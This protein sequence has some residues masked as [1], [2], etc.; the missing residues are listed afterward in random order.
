MYL[1]H[2]LRIGLDLQ[3]VTGLELVVINDQLEYVGKVSEY[4][5]IGITRGLKVGLCCVTYDYA[6]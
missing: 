5:K 2:S 4:Q 3:V 1:N 6:T